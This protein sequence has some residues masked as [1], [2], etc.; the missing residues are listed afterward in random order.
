MTATNNDCAQCEKICTEQIEKVTCGNTCHE[1]GRYAYSADQSSYLYLLTNGNL[2][3]HKIGIG[4]VGKD[5]GHLQ[6]LI[7]TGWTVYGLWH[8][9][10]KGK[11]FRWEQEIFKQ[12]SAQI[13]QPEEGSR[14]LI[15]RRDRHWVES[16]SAS[17]ISVFGL[18]QLMST[19][20]SG[21]GK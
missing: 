9:D 12:L 10:D 20:V 11:T 15:G 8:A 13:D 17:A 16:I 2:Q 4:T 18:S 6:Q 14:G 21:K 1:C 3:L 5:K 19:V 7:E